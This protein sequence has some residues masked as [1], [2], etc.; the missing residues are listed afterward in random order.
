[1]EENVE[2]SYEEEE[3]AEEQAIDAEDAEEQEFVVSPGTRTS[4]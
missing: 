1:M 2:A 3:E 4:Q